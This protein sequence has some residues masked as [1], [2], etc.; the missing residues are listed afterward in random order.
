MRIVVGKRRGPQ[1]LAGAAV[2]REN[3]AAFADHHRDVAL[4]AALEYRD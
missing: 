1:E 3:S 2:E 4:F